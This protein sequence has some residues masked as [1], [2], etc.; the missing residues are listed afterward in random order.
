MNDWVFYHIVGL[1]SNVEAIQ[2]VSSHLLTQMEEHGVVSALLELAPYLKLYSVYAN[3]FNCSSKL[4]DEL[5][6]RSE[7]IKRLLKF[8]EGREEMEGLK[9]NSLLLTPI[10]RVPR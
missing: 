10:Q 6:D 8:Q 1:F 4:L 9:L 3:N 2:S 7:D 5:L